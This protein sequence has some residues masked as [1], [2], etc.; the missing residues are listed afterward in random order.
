M[1][2]DNFNLKHAHEKGTIR[3]HARS[4]LKLKLKQCFDYMTAVLMKSVSHFF[5]IF[6]PDEEDP[7]YDCDAEDQGTWTPNRIAVWIINGVNIVYGLVGGFLTQNYLAYR[8]LR[9]MAFAAGVDFSDMID[10]SY[11]TPLTVCMD[12]VFFFCFYLALVVIQSIFYVFLKWVFREKLRDPAQ[13]CQIGFM[14][15]VLCIVLSG[16]VGIL[17]PFN[18]FL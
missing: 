16:L 13:Q 4:E 1:L 6:E 17:V 14:Y 10:R 8:S 5:H 18:V 11:A 15:G 3:K 2:F 7:L 9:F 12:I